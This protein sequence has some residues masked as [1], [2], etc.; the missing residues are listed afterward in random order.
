MVSSFGALIIIFSLIVFFYN[1]YISYRHFA[2]G[3]F[4]GYNEYGEEEIDELIAHNKIFATQITVLCKRHGPFIN[5]MIIAQKKRQASIE[6]ETNNKLKKKVRKKK[7]ARKKYFYSLMSVWIEKFNWPVNEKTII[8]PTPFQTGFPESC[9]A[10][11]DL[12]VI[13]HGDIVMYLMVVIIFLT[14]IVASISEEFSEGNPWYNLKMH[15][16]YYKYVTSNLPL[17]IA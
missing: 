4:V 9:S 13:F 6:I 2:L 3:E 12:I 16:R 14:S 10:S 5:Q 1:F 8:A 15:N 11:I 17:E 7:K